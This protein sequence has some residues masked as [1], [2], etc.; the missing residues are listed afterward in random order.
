[1]SSVEQGKR[2]TLK[3]LWRQF[4]FPLIV[5]VGW[6][7]FKG[8]EAMPTS[9]YAAFFATVVAQFSSAFFLLSWAWGQ[10]NRVDRQQDTTERLQLIQRSLAE[11]QQA[12]ARLVEMQTQQQDPTFRPTFLEASR[13]TVEASALSAQANTAALTA[14]NATLTPASLGGRYD[15]GLFGNYLPPATTAHSPPT[16]TVVTFPLEN[17]KPEH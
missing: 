1:M 4:R 17:P 15:G 5:A 13:L 8:W 14:L 3:E 2:G 12:T 16:M 7:A 9:S 6:A 11:S 10:Y